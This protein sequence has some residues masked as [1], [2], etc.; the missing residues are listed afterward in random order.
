MSDPNG[1]DVDIAPSDAPVNTE[2]QPG[3]VAV[4]VESITTTVTTE[5]VPD[6]EP[7]HSMEVDPVAVIQ[8]ESAI[9]S[10]AQ[11]HPVLIGETTIQSTSAV[12]P[13]Q[14]GLG[15]DIFSLPAELTP[16]FAASSQQSRSA[17][18]SNLNHYQEPGLSSILTNGDILHASR[19][20]P[21]PE[22]ATVSQPAP[23]PA[24]SMLDVLPILRPSS[25]ARMVRT[26]Y[27]YDPLMMLHCQDGYTPTADN[28]V[29][30]GDG[31]PEE[32]MRIKRIFSRLAESGLIKRMRK[33]EFAQVTFDQVLLVHTEDHWNK[34]QGT[35]SE[36][37]TTALYPC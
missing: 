19:K 33:L 7:Q 37:M 9:E 13:P 34:V 29:D 14:A 20:S 24:T 35:E 5:P 16:S 11:S 4:T 36:F 2:V 12:P 15:P 31:H 3:E 1:I 22:K 21:T 10:G 6:V 32:P 27:I 28:V 23:A 26:G 18:P 25:P 17:G 30:V 8:H